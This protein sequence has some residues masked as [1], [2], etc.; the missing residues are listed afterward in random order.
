MYLMYILITYL[1]IRIFEKMLTGD[2][3]R[4]EGPLNLPQIHRHIFISC[5]SPRNPLEPS[6]TL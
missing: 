2:K 1:Q 4:T 6:R 5:M 3:T